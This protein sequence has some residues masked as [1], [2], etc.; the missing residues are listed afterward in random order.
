MVFF[1]FL[2]I[3]ITLNS[4]TNTDYLKEIN[5]DIWLPFIEAYGTLNVEKYKSLQS[6]DFIRAEGEGKSLP[7]Y[8]EYFDNVGVW[9]AD[10]KKEGFEAQAVHTPSEAIDF[11]RDKTPDLILLDMNFSNDTSGDDGLKMLTLIKKRTPSFIPSGVSV[12][13]ITG[14]ATIDLA[15]RGMK[16]GAADFIHKPWQNVHLMQSIRTILNLNKAPQP[17]KGKPVIVNSS[18]GGRG[19]LA[20]YDFSHIIGEDPAFLKILETI[21]RVDAT[22]ASLT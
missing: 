21:G 8:K 3:S 18:F 5:Q 4:Q 6:E 1:L 7:S 17:P 12:I 13:L 22:D 10:V 11:L 15:V 2:F 14:W 9:F 16:M 20:Q 19:A